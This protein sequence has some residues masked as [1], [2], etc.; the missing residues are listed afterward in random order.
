MS[1][2]NR[3]FRCLINPQ[4]ITATIPYNKMN[5]EIEIAHV[6][7][8]HSKRFDS[9]EAFVF[10][11]G[12]SP[13]RW[14]WCRAFTIAWISCFDHSWHNPQFWIRVSG[15]GGFTDTT[16]TGKC[17][18]AGRSL[19]VSYVRQLLCI[20]QD[21]NKHTNKSTSSEYRKN[22]LHTAHEFQYMALLLYEPFFYNNF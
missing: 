10:S 21:H 8:V 4:F 17:C 14:W 12:F 15:L 13:V 20:V 5:W 3:G 6:H 9:F 18:T 7:I 16:A 19:Y 11:H 22:Y 1:R 2:F